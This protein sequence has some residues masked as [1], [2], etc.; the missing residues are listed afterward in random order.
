MHLHY[1][2]M[3]FTWRKYALY[4]AASSIMMVTAHGCVEP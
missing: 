2:F 3:K 1:Y 4:Q